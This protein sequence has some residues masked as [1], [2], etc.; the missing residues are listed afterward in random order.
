MN[1]DIFQQEAEQ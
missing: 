1:Q